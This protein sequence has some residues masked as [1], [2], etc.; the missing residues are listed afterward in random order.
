MTRQH[1]QLRHPRQPC[2]D[3]RAPT[4]SLPGDPDHRCME[5]RAQAW[6]FPPPPR[7][8]P[9]RWRTSP[10][11]AEA[12]FPLGS[13]PCHLHGNGHLRAAGPVHLGVLHVVDTQAPA[14]VLNGACVIT[15]DRGS[16]YT[17]QR[18]LTPR[19]SARR[20]SVPYGIPAPIDTTTAGSYTLTYRVTDGSGDEVTT[21]RTVNVL[22]DPGRCSAAPGQW[23]SHR[24][25]GQ[26]RMLHTTT[27]LPSGKV[28]VVDHF[29]S[30]PSCTSDR[31]GPGRP[32]A[33]R[34]PP[35]RAHRHPAPRRPACSSRGASMAAPSGSFAE[36]YDAGLQTPGSSAG[37]MARWA[38]AALHRHPAA[39]RQG[40]ASP[41]ASN[42]GGIMSTSAELY[43]PISNSWSSHRLH[44]R[45]PRLLPR[46]HPAARWQGARYGR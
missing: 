13:T 33:P 11:P 9:A 46:R 17:E 38:A 3:N 31:P 30:S 4:L 35:P 44:G 27:L 8:T 7:V 10:H 37:S 26:P 32:R 24:R 28:L 15:L 43:K 41:A 16:P 1:G 18:G 6:R 21:T 23:T 36:V 14:L 19:T 40:A 45:E 34:W 39:L 25:C 22:A 42:A 2:R 12:S 5:E 20:D 29:T